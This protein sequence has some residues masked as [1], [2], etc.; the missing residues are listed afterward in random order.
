MSKTSHQGDLTPLIARSNEQVK[1]ATWIKSGGGKERYN[2]WVTVFCNL[3]KA[4]YLQNVPYSQ[5]EDLGTSSME[6][7][8][9]SF[10]LAITVAR[11]TVYYPNR[12]NCQEETKRAYKFQSNENRILSIKR[13]LFL[14]LKVRC[15]LRAYL[16]NKSNKKFN[17]RTC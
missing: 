16:P 11:L 12:R 8:R 3:P 14:V 13:W 2:L 9:F 6:K 15:L 17:P 4:E 1:K 7:T 5:S 10:F